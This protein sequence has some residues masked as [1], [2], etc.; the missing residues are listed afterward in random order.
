MFS[1]LK[2]LTTKQDALPSIGTTNAAATPMSGSLQKKFS[3]GVQYN[4]KYTF[5]I[6]PFVFLEKKKDYF[7]KC[8]I[9]FQNVVLFHF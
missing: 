2:K 8:C 6:F 1:A 5:I 4:S 7:S 3:R 9:I